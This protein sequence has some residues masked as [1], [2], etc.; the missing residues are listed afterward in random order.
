[1]F[2]DLGNYNAA[3]GGPI[4][5]R[6]DLLISGEA[7]DVCDSMSNLGNCYT[8]PEGQSGHT[9]LAGLGKFTLEEMEVYGCSN[10]YSLMDILKED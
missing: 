2:L 8:A 4:F 1:V 10:M 9:F 5:G 7:H 3:S 6:A